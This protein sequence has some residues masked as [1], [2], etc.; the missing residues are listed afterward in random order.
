[1]TPPE[2]S[3]DTPILHVLHPPDPVTRRRFWSDL[4]LAVG[5]SLLKF[6]DDFMKRRTK[7]TLRTSSAMG[8]QLTHH[9]GFMTCSTTSPDRLLELS[10]TVDLW[11]HARAN[12]NLHL[13]VLLLHVQTLSFQCFDDG[14]TDMKSSHSLESK[15]SLNGATGP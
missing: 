1:M 5:C 3:R 14:I 6:R 8:R 11:D 2:L 10:W 12:W 13:V 9:W 15:A 4:N 7:F